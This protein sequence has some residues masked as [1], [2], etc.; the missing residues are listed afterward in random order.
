MN[1]GT[2]PQTDYLAARAGE[3]IGGPDGN[4]RLKPESVEGLVVYLERL[5][6]PPAA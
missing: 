3:F 6:G 5:H 1:D 2:L 4:L